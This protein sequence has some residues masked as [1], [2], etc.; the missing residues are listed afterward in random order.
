MLQ[1]RSVLVQQRDPFMNCWVMFG[2]SAGNAA[3][4]A[5]VGS[6]TSTMTARKCGALEQGSSVACKSWQPVEEW[7]EFCT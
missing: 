2:G 5:G 4:T 1:C 3:R 7:L 6:C